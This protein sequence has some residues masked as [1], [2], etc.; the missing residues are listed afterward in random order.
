MGGHAQAGDLQL[1]TLTPKHASMC[2][3][4][5]LVSVVFHTADSRAVA[6]DGRTVGWTRALWEF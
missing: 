5:C 3:D 2:R 1:A 4:W 6:G